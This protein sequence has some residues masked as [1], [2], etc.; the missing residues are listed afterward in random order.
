MLPQAK[1]IVS[2]SL[3]HLHAAPALSAAPVRRGS[4][5]VAPGDSALEY[6]A[7]LPASARPSA[8]ADGSAREPLADDCKPFAHT[9]SRP[10]E[11][12]SVYSAWMHSAPSRRRRASGA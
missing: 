9:K 7:A 10:T 11:V 5:H 2:D 12:S 3:T 1:G 4:Y 8:A 6:T